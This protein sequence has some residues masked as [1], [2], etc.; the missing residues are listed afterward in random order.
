MSVSRKRKAVGSLD[1]VV[2]PLAALSPLLTAGWN[3]LPAV[4]FQ[5]ICSFAP[6]P[7]YDTLLHLSGVCR[8]WSQRL[9]GGNSTGLDCWRLVP[10]LKLTPRRSG[11]HI[12]GHTRLVLPPSLV[13]A[14][15]HSLRRLR[16]VVLSLAGCPGSDYELYLAPFARSADATYGSRVEQFT[17]DL[18]D[19]LHSLS[20]VQVD[21]LSIALSVFLQRC[22]PLESFALIPERG[23]WRPTVPSVAA[24]RR[25][26]SGPLR[27]LEL[28]AAAL[29]AMVWADKLE[30]TRPWKRAASLQSLILHSPYISEPNRPLMALSHALPSLTHLHLPEYHDDAAV[31]YIMQQ[32][33]QRL[34]FLRLNNILPSLPSAVRCCTALQSLYLRIGSSAQDHLESVIHSLPLL[35]QLHQ[36]TVVESRGVRVDPSKSIALRLP[37]DCAL[38]FLQLRFTVTKVALQLA[39]DDADTAAALPPSLLCLSL[40]L[41]VGD[42]QSVVAQLASGG[43]SQ[44]THCHISASGDDEQAE[45]WTQRLAALQN[46]LGAGVWCESEEAVEQH[47][48]DRRWQHSMGLHLLDY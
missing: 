18:R 12:D 8:L 44:L 19:D 17:I 21:R 30:P 48:L 3:K 43:G 7:V 14:A 20:S 6:L 33:G 45:E 5:H 22:P 34:S 23:Q 16:S 27:H 10:A 46:K 28:E 4:L 40:R 42:V 1:A 32:L 24:L 31:Q 36:L 41:Q 25:L 35:P 13:S 9:D 2:S 26:C 15:L 11:L 38:A 37:A 39:P 47:R 29:A